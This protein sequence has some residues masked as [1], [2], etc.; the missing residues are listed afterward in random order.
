[1]SHKVG[2]RF[3]VKYENLLPF[4][5]W[6]L[7]SE[8]ID[9]W[10]SKQAACRKIWEDRVRCD[11]IIWCSSGRKATSEMESIYVSFI[12]L[13]YRL[14]LEE[15]QPPKL[16]LSIYKANILFLYID[17]TFEILSKLKEVQKSLKKNQQHSKGL[18]F[19]IG[20]YLKYFRKL[21]IT[22]N[23]TKDTL[24]K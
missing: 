14:T 17:F 6:D 22:D 3:H 5:R 19:F 13:S 9:M 15:T 21:K 8:L 24:Y 23:N 7:Y 16:Q 10:D 2:N 20:P 12:E 18:I 4:W 11:L 1:M